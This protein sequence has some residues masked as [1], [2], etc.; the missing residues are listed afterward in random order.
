MTLG[1]SNS[2][3]VVVTPLTSL[4][5]NQM[6]KFTQKGITAEFVGKAQNDEQA[7]LSVLNGRIQLVHV[8]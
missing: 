5:L 1:V 3:V 6:E 2:I 4:M 7:V 8:H